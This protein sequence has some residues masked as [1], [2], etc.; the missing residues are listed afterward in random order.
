MS[1]LDALRQSQMTFSSKK[2]LLIKLML[3]RPRKRSRMRRLQWSSQVR[4]KRKSSKRLTWSR[5]HLIMKLLW[6]IK[7]KKKWSVV[8]LFADTLSAPCK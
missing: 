4:S 3:K 6:K 5:L 1:E 2:T 7:S 8:K